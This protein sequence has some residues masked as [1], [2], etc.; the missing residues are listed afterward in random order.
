MQCSEI[1]QSLKHILHRVA[2][3]AIAILYGS[4]TR[5]DARPDSDIE[6]LIIVDNY[7]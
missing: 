5:G 1:V 4:E 7:I 3:D 2:P 6:I